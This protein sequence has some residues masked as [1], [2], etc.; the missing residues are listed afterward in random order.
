MSDK[1]KCPFCQQE[2]KYDGRNE[3]YMCRNPNCKHLLGFGTKELWQAL[4]I[5]STE[6]DLTH[7]ALVK[8]TQELDRTKK[9]LDE[10][11]YCCTEWEKQALDYKAE[12]IK[13][14]TALDVAVD[15]LKMIGSGQIIEHSVLFHEDDNKI[16]IANKALD[17][18]NET[19][20]GK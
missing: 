2:L 16:T 20:G 10:S 5:E 13:L 11:E 14:S 19:K 4:I 6:H 8:R 7:D 15:A 3:V 9:T 17:Q 12:N 1:L 18:I